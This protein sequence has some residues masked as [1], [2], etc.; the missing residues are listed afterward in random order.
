MDANVA[1]AEAI[2]DFQAVSFRYPSG[3]QALQEATFTVAEGDRV[4]VI[5]PNGG[6]KTTLLKLALGLLKPDS[7]TIQTCGHAPHR[8][9]Q[10]VGYV[11]QVTSVDARFPITCE[12][13][14]GMGLLQAKAK[15]AGAVPQALEQVG[16]PEF[17]QRSFQ[18]LSGGQRQRVLIARALVAR[19][20]LLLLD[21][22]TAHL[23]PEAAGQLRDLLGQL[24]Q[25]RTVITVTHDLN[26]VDAEVQRVLCVNRTV[27]LHPTQALEQD[28]WAHL[29][30][31]PLAQVHHDACLATHRHLDS[32]HACAQHPPEASA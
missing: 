13:V 20:R 27:H 28:L 31:P 8:G 24:R 17:G 7:G 12:R 30:G 2:L 19:P 25:S 26:F 15:P 14:V 9:C 6:G 29:Y 5:G 3:V 22:P 11:P 18:A 4:A 32:D 16:L 10:Q 21:E 1:E 23:D